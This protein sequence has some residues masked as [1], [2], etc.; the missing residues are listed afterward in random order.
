MNSHLF[1]LPTCS[2]ISLRIKGNFF[3]NNYYKFS[4]LNYCNLLIIIMHTINID[5]LIRAYIQILNNLGFQH[6]PSSWIIYNNHI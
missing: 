3:P 2:K 1:L 6:F 4:L 5:I